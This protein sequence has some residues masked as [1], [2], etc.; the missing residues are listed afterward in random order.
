MIKSRTE[1]SRMIRGGRSSSARGVLYESTSIAAV[2]G[3]I[4]SLLWESWGSPDLWYASTRKKSHGSRLKKAFGLDE[5]NTCRP[6]VSAVGMRLSPAHTLCCWVA[7]C[8]AAAS[9]RDAAS[10]ASQLALAREMPS[11]DGAWLADAAKDDEI[12]ALRAER[13]ALREELS[14][15][16]KC[17]ASCTPP[18]V[19]PESTEQGIRSVRPERAET[20]GLWSHTTRR[21]PAG[22]SVGRLGLP[23][24]ASRH[25]IALLRFRA[26]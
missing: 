6:S 16:R 24:A 12:A 13:Q 22:V 2:Y 5:D 3:T 25:C 15:L 8:A 21:T 10:N 18:P 7:H 14:K 26:C 23:D 11:L 9:W 19:A 4:C 17:A 1:A 20:D